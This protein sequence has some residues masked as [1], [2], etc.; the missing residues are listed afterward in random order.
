MTKGSKF[1][2]ALGAVC[3][4]WFL[5]ML[6]FR[7]FFYADMY[8]A[9]EDPYGISDILELVMGMVFYALLSISLVTSLVL[10]FRGMPKTKKFAGG[11]IVF[12]IVLFL[13]FP[14]LHDIMARL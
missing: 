10:L 11:L 13:T 4:G 2:I 7:A 12:C 14:P 9:P 6:A 3:F 5:F 1:V 8:K